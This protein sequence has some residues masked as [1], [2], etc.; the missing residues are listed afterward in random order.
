MNNLD[1]VILGALLHDV[2]KLLE[3]GEEF[4]AYRNDEEQ[5]KIDCCIRKNTKNGQEKATSY[6]S[7]HSR[8][9]CEW[10][11]DSGHVATL[12]PDGYSRTDDKADHWLNLA[13]KHH[14]AT[15]PLQKLIAAAD[16]FSSGERER[17]RTFGHEINYKSRLE[18]N[19]A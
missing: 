15:T 14:R 10:L 16:H 7:L 8:H 2:G 17:I 9:F 6:H 18:S 11:S 1:H 3:R 13:A 5:W 4:S 19:G 12:R